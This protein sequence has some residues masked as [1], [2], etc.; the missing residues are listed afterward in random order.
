MLLKTFPVGVDMELKEEGGYWVIHCNWTLPK[1][2]FCPYRKKV[3][4]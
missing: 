3:N 1:C 4:Q 2:F